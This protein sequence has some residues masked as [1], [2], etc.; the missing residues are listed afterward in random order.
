MAATHDTDYRLHG[1]PG[2]RT[3][4]YKKIIEDTYG[5]LINLQL[6]F[7]DGSKGDIRISTSKAETGTW[8]VI[9]TE[10]LNIPPNEPT[11]H[12]DYPPDTGNLS[13]NI[14]HEFGHALGLLHEHQHP[15]RT[16]EFNIRET[17][18]HFENEYN[19]GV[20]RTYHNIFKKA[21]PADVITSP[22][23]QQSIM[24]YAMNDKL[25]WKQPSTGANYVLSENDKTFLPTLYPHYNGRPR[26]RPQ[27]PR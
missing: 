22:Y 3:R 11:M 5:P 10:A 9:G 20:P 2:A 14:L 17:Y 25:L 15:D 6:K 4:I 18:K 19:W 8:S 23:D 13:A 7:V 16:L 26:E 24:H 27:T 12:I 21:D 1:H